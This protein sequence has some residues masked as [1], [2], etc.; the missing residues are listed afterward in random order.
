MPRADSYKCYRAPSKERLSNAATQDWALATFVWYWRSE[1]A[2]SLQSFSVDANCPRRSRSQ[3]GDLTPASLQTVRAQWEKER[4]R[5]REIQPTLSEPLTYSTTSTTLT[6]IWSIALTTKQD[7]FVGCCWRC[8]TSAGCHTHGTLSAIFS[9]IVLLCD[10]DESVIYRHIKKLIQG[11]G[12]RET[13]D[14]GMTRWL[15]TEPVDQ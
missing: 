2:L 4:E 6:S 9:F 15:P 1:N 5:E 12:P 3:E 14:W 8:Q 11:F 10:D 13:R 7:P